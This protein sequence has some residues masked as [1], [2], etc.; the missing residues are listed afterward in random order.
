MGAAGPYT[1]EDWIINGQHFSGVFNDVQGLV[2]L[3]N[4]LDPDGNWLLDDQSFVIIGG[5]GKQYGPLKVRQT[6]TGAVAVMEVNTNNSADKARVTLPEGENLLVATRLADGFRDTLK[7]MVACVHAD[8]F[9]TVMDMNQVDTICLDL[10]EIMGEV[11]GL[12]NICQSNSGAAQI[13]LIP[14][15]WCLE[16][17]GMEPGLTSACFVLCDEYGICDT[18]YLDVEV[19]AVAES[20]TQL[21]EDHLMTLVN[22][23]VT[24]DVLA[25]DQLASQVLSMNIVKKPLHGAAIVNADNTIT[26]LPSADYCNDFENAS[27]DHFLYEVCTAGGCYSQVVWVTVRCSELLIYNGFSPNGDGVNDYFV[28]EGLQKYPDHSLQIFNRWGNLVFKTGDYRSDWG[29]TWGQNDL[30]DGT[31]FYLLDLGDGTRYTGFIEINR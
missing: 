21:A 27:P 8:Y 20:E 10:E 5:N 6:A 18:T 30:P 1:L 15:T 4:S 31:Y 13:G 9:S 12:E 14:G 29:G 24:G 22:Q 7:V 28:I 16:C 26:Y 25:N 3:M 23:S 2:A 17:V 11:T 19:R